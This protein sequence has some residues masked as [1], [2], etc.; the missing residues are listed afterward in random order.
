M[1]S[2]WRTFDGF[3]A[4]MGVRPVGMTLDRVDNGGDY[5]P[6]NCRWA[7]PA[8][9]ACN[10]RGGLTPSEVQEIRGRIEHGESASSIARR[11]G[12][13]YN[14]IYRVRHGL[15]WQENTH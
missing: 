14:C 10:R 15:S 2:S 4:D 11:M 3:L 12:R 6:A 1:C 9:Q 8:Q 7:T 13:A 5:T